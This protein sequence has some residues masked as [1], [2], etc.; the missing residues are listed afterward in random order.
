MYVMYVKCAMYV[1]YLRML[2]MC[3]C[4][5]VYVCFDSMYVRMYVVFCI[6]VRLCMH[7]MLC[8]YAELSHVCSLCSVWM[9]C[10]RVRI[11]KM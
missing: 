9:I 7:A 4:H 8:M 11:V 10:T 5:V 2:C 6:S 3:V 1:L